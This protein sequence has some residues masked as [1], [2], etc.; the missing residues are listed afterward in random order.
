MTYDETLKGI[1][2]AVRI[3]G[4]TA[5]GVQSLEDKLRFQK[6]HSELEKAQSILR[7]QIYEYEDALKIHWSLPYC[8]LCG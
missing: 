5:R 6:L 7:L 1:M 4:E 2:R 8:G 3:A